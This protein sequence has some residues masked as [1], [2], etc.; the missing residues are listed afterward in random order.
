MSVRRRNRGPLAVTTVV[1]LVAGCSAGPEPAPTGTSAATSDS[2][3]PTVAPTSA[4]ATTRAAATNPVESTVAPRREPSMSPVELDQPS[5]TGTGL[6]ARLISVSAIDAKAQIP[7]EITG[8][9]LAITIEVGNTGRRSAD[10]EFV[11]VSLLDSD[12]APGAEMTAAPAK[13]L[14]GRVAAKANARGV[15]VF[16]VPENKRRPVTVSVSIGHAPVLVFTGNA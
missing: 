8:P 12:S 9:A 11:S 5:S 16:R 10:L 4:P 2:V 7:G 6:T 1:L 14:T 13:P 15:Y 3:T